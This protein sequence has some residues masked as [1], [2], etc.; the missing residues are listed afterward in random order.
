MG[1]PYI[2]DLV[3][4]KEVMTKQVVEIDENMPLSILE[5]Y[6]LEHHHTGY[7]VTKGGKLVGIVTINDIPKE[8]TGTKNL[9]VGDIMSKT[10]ITA[11]PDSKIKEVLDKMNK[12]KL[13]RLPIVKKDAPELI[14]GIITRH[15]ILEAIRLASLRSE[16]EVD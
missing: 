14:E 12:H 9:T 1:E 4:A 6:Y 5:L 3:D 10:V 15:D 16:S 2:L 8:D 13:G 7:P 11:N